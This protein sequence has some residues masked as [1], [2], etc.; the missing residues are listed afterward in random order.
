MWFQPCTTPLTLKFSNRMIPYKCISWAITPCRNI[1][2]LPKG[3]KIPQ[4]RT[5]S[6]WTACSVLQTR[7]ITVNGSSGFA[8]IWLWWRAWLGQ[9]WG[10]VKVHAGNTGERVSKVITP[11]LSLSL[12][13]YYPAQL[14]SGLARQIVIQVPTEP[15]QSFTL[16]ACCCPICSIIIIISG[17]G[18][19]SLFTTDSRGFHIGFPASTHS[20]LTE[21]KKCLVRSKTCRQAGKSR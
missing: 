5:K 12:S 1:T 17:E 6:P 20:S 19:C 4:N 14:M 7:H 15:K 21:K 9:C 16:Q 18:A 11:A 2:A 8:F 3:T 13:S 10:G